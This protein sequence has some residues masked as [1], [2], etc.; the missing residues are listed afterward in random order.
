MFSGKVLLVDAS[1][2]PSQNLS[3]SHSIKF[4]VSSDTFLENRVANKS[5]F[6][7]HPSQRINVTDI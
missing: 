5:K 3:Y 7:H 4:H 2:K 6:T 1:T